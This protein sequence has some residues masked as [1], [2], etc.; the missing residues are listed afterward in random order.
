MC[1]LFLQ[2]H[3]H[4]F[5]QQPLQVN[6]RI[7]LQ[8]QMTVVDEPMCGEVNAFRFRR[9]VLLKDQFLLDGLESANQY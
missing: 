6:A 7:L 9:Q 3:N 4:V 8:H 5:E 2:Q 1:Y